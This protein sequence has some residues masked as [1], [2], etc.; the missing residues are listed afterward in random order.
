MEAISQG[1]IAALVG[2]DS[3]GGLT[4]E[5]QDILQYTLYYLVN[6]CLYFFYHAFLVIFKN[7]FLAFIM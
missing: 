1:I 2:K 6:K 5:E 7:I 3:F 4:D